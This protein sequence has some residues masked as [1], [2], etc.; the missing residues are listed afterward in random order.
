MTNIRKIIPFCKPIDSD[1]FLPGSKSIT[2]RA[3]VLASCCLGKTVLDNV[4]ES[5]DTQIMLDALRQ[6][7]VLIECGVNLSSG[8]YQT[9]ITGI[10]GNFTVAKADIYIGNSGTSVRFLTALLALSGSGEYRLHGKARM[11][12]RPISDLVEVLRLLGG[13]IHYENNNNSP[14]LLIGRRGVLD[15]SIIESGTIRVSVSGGVSS[16]FLSALLMSVPMVSK[17]ADVEILV[18]GELVS[19]PYVLMTIRMMES[20]GIVAVVNTDFTSFKFRKGEI[21]CVPEVYCIEPD[22][23]A[24][25]YFFA[26]AAVCGGKV[27]VNG[28]SQKSMQGDI[29]FIDCLAKM[30][31]EVQFDNDKNTTTVSRDLNKPLKGI[32]IDMNSISDTAQTLGVVSLFADGVTE[33]KNIEH[34][35]Y[36]ETDRIADL[37]T[38]LRKFGAT[39]EEQKDGLRIIPP[40]KIIPANIE[41]YDDHRM[42]MSFAIA[43]LKVEGVVIKNPECV[44]NTFPNFFTKLEQLDIK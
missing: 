8:T 3:L 29:R 43:G 28:L 37:A 23:S 32:S 14:P 33:I 25:S 15:K 38:E 35:R 24:A 34:V 9:I 10:G 26:A 13:D 6:L 27:Q 39:V 11:H 36:K 41:T 30:G 31:C 18:E 5:E 16:Q 4:L 42:A 21:Y 22:A 12:Q 19:R 17:E 1:V 2:N 44:Q 20:F 7:G 40:T